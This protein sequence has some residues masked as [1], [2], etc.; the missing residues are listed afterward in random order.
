MRVLVTGGLGNLGTYTLRA[1]AREGH[2]LRCFDLETP[3]NK[4]NARALG[5]TI[6]LLWG[7]IRDPESVARAVAGVEVIVHLAS[8]IPPPAHDHPDLAEAVNVG[9]TR[10]VLAAAVSQA[11]PPRMLFASSLD[12][13]GPTL[14]QPPPRTIA[15]PLI[16][17]DNYSHHKILCEGEVRS[18]GIPWAIYRFANMPILGNQPAHPMMFEIPLATR[19]EVLH[20]AD[21]AEAIATGVTTG[22]I[23]NAVWLIGGGPT[24]QVT[25]GTYLASMLGALG[26]PMLPES[27]FGHTPYC[28]DWL[29]TAASEATL[30]YQHHSFAAIVH[31]VAQGV[32]P[33]RYLAPLAR[34]IVVR[35]LLRRSPYY[36]AT[37][38]IREREA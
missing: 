35:S 18:A 1:L 15:D 27:A 13:F 9:G 20:P 16:P 28:T 29:D 17:T 14:D 36:R 21:A 3:R 25:Y 22:A 2:I 34:P 23:W 33:I 8:I 31:D 38:S 10:N 24:C 26:I 32:G 6:E 5:D 4:R 12:V 11:T 30:H 19:M 7:D 37:P